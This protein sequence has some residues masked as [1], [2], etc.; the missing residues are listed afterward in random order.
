MSR[1]RASGKKSDST[2]FADYIEASSAVNKRCGQC[3]HTVQSS[4]R[5]RICRDQKA[6]QYCNWRI[7]GSFYFIMTV[8]STIGYGNFAPAT[9]QGKLTCVVFVVL[10]VVCVGWLLVLIG[11]SGHALVVDCLGMRGRR[12]QRTETLLFCAF[13]A[14]FFLGGAAFYAK[15]Q[16]WGFWEAL[17]FVLI[18]VSTVGLGDYVP[19][20]NDDS[21]LAFAW[22]Y[23]VLSI[24]LIGFTLSILENRAAISK[25]ASITRAS[26]KR[27]ASENFDSNR[28]QPNDY[29]VD[30]D[31]DDDDDDALGQD[32]RDRR[33]DDPRTGLPNPTNTVRFDAEESAKTATAVAVAVDRDDDQPP[34]PPP[35]PADQS[36]CPEWYFCY[37]SEKLEPSIVGPGATPTAELEKQ[38]HL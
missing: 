25:R 15:Q 9:T 34:A 35:Y 21:A 1:A 27:S 37:S 32:G 14:A 2:F 11:E 28:R 20:I 10:G 29:D 19:N 33:T 7:E 36:L 13:C 22:I 24:A 23:I 31:D 3:S 8:I 38:S 17:Y 6:L 16:Q 12:G 26:L 5:N 18:S 30:D 4:A